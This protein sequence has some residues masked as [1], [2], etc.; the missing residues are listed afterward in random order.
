MI[1]K[2]SER[3][4]H[5]SG[6]NAEVLDSRIKSVGNKGIN[7]VTNLAS[8]INASQGIAADDFDVSVA[9]FNIVCYYCSFYL[10]YPGIF[11]AYFVILLLFYICFSLGS[12]SLPST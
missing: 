6:E 5:L 9:M 4:A 7:D 11:L 1:K 10:L 12:H 3:P 8:T 2:R